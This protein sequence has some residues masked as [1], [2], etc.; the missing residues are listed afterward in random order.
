MLSESYI[1]SEI[2][3]ATQ[4]IEIG[5]LGLSRFEFDPNPFIEAVLLAIALS[6]SACEDLS[7]AQPPCLLDLR[8]FLDG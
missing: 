1:G 2:F 5:L 8:S 3:H 4:S 6:E 7:R